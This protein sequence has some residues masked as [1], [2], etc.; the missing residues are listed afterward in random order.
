MTDLATQARKLA[1]R[2]V[3]R[4]KVEYVGTQNTDYFVYAFGDLLWQC[5]N[6]TTAHKVYEEAITKA[7]SAL[8]EGMREALGALAIAIDNDLKRESVSSSW[9]H[10]QAIRRTAES[11]KRE[12]GGRE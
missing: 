8:L 2:L 1:E 5:Q 4:R 11:L 7:E 6:K 12:L 3:T 9:A 10:R